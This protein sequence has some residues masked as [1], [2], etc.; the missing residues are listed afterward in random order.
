MRH[1]LNPRYGSLIGI[2]GNICTGKSLTLTVFKKLGFQ[3]VSMDKYVNDT[4]NT[5]NSLKN[6][7]AERFPNSLVNGAISK[8]ILGDIVFHNQNA[9]PTC[10]NL[11]E[12]NFYLGYLLLD[13]I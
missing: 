7:I 13:L 5:D 11:P 4:I 2:T 6:K 8:K 10:S 1:K 9:M 12:T 3:T